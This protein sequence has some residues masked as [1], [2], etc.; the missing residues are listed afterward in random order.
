MPERQLRIN[1]KDILEVVSQGLGDEVYCDGYFTRRNG[2]IQVSSGA[3]VDFLVDY[4]SELKMGVAYLKIHFSEADTVDLFV[5]SGKSEKNSKG[6]FVKVNGS[7]AVFW[8]PG[9]IF[10]RDYF[11]NGNIRQE[12]QVETT[13]CDDDGFCLGIPGR[14][15][16]TVELPVVFAME[17]GDEFVSQITSTVPFEEQSVN[18]DIHFKYE[19]IGDVWDY[20]IAGNIYILMRYSYDIE[21]DIRWV[22]QLTAN[23]L[24]SYQVYLYD[25]TGKSVYR[26]LYDLVAYSVM[27]SQDDDGRWRHGIWSP[28]TMET[29]LRFQVSGVCLLAS[30]Y[31]K[32]NRGVFL[33]KAQM[34]MDYVLGLADEMSGDGL[35]FKHDS[36]EQKDSWDKCRYK[37]DIKSEAFGKSQYNTLCLNTHIWTL[38]GLCKLKEASGDDRYDRYVDK[39]MASLKQVMQARPAEGVY[40]LVYRLRDIARIRVAKGGGRIV[41]ELRR[42]YEKMLQGWILPRL[43]RKYPRLSMPNGFIERDLTHSRLS[44][45][46]HIVTLEDLLTLYAYIPSEWLQETL[47]TS[48]VYT[49][50]SGFLKCFAQNNTLANNFVQML[51]LYSGMIDE[52]YLM[53]LPEYIAYLNELGFGISS[54]GIS[55]MLIISDEIGVCTDNNRL[56]VLTVGH[57]R[58]LMAVIVNPEQQAQKAQIELHFLTKQKVNLMIVDSN[59]QEITLDGPVEIPACGLVKFIRL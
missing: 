30:Y 23:S 59:E 13:Q 12:Y 55:N 44:D 6:T 3:E 54:G 27:L 51:M 40:R 14:Q 50:T 58:D 4:V 56:R 24:Y 28:E 18:Y 57:G 10:A 21:S 22:C 19:Q 32:T 7:D 17:G 49:H 1:M 43:K 33:A 29:H 34:A 8:L 11:A 48:V 31:K 53:L 36:L 47:R 39:G 42:R 16:Q 35:W 5:D 26:F 25:L 15:N 2:K 45:Y 38:L 52:S 20:L 37:N 9:R 41:S 46:Y